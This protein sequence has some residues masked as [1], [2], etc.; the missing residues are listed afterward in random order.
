LNT[1]NIATAN[2]TTLPPA[3]ETSWTK[4]HSILANPIFARGFREF[5][6]AASQLPTANVSKYNDLKQ[7]VKGEFG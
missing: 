4:A 5:V 2:A 1:K 3:I 6:G 7:N